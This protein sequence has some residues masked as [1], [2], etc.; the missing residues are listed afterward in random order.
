MRVGQSVLALAL[1]ALAAVLIRQT[2]AFPPAPAGIPVG[3]AD[4]PR[5]ILLFIA[6]LCLLMIVEAWRRPATEPLYF[7]AWRVVA[8]SAIL[9]AAYVEMVARFG[10]FPPTVVYL[11]LMLRLLQVRR[12]LHVAIT[13]LA[14]T[15]FV[16]VFFVRILGLPLPEGGLRIG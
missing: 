11:L 1:L 12:W 15:L 6:A 13:T 10:Y 7:G 14:F 8:A 5:A 9:F 3:A 4:Y 16:Y 2:R